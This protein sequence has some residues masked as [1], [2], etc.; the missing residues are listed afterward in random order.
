MNNTLAVDGDILAFRIASVC[1]EEMKQA[2]NDLIDEKINEIVLNTN[3][4]NLR[5][6][7]SGENNFRYDVAVSKPYKGNREGLRKPQHLQYCRNYLTLNYKAITVDGYEADDGIASDMVQNGAIHAGQDKDIKQIAGTHYNFVTQETEE[8]SKNQALL[9][10]Y[11]QV[12]TGDASDNIGG[13]P[14]VGE[15]TAV[16]VLESPETVIED[17]KAY[18]KEICEKSLPEVDVAAYWKET[19]QLVQLVTDLNILDMVTHTAKVN[20]L[21]I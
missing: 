10:L 16:R 5:I 9:N 7:L 12:L 11:R 4:D 13:L 21:R 1:E 20:L 2:C 6:Y 17:A 3:A 18:F 8:V 15:K 19:V 14:R